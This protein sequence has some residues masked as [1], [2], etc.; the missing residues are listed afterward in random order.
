[1]RRSPDST[2]FS[3]RQLRYFVEIAEQRSFSRAA[4][5]SRIAQSALSRQ[6][7]QLEEDLGTPLL[8]RNARGVSLTTAGE[9]FLAST[10]SIL[11]GLDAARR[12]LA[13]WLASRGLRF[14]ELV[15][16]NGS[17]LS[18][19]ERIAPASLAALL[20]H[21]ADSPWGALLR[22]SL[23]VVG[24]DGTMRHRLAGDA[25]AGRAWIKTGS[26]SEVRSIAGYVDGASGRQHVVVLIVNGPAA[27]ASARVQDRLLRWVHAQG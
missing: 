10:Q 14:P 8:T 4:A 27:A 21:A 24:F 19:A 16:D 23:P 11:R 9:R 5:A 7:L 3:L 18:R 2:Q 1:M 12:A 22:E 20:R 13:D 6:I 25:V 17:G 15:V 26:L